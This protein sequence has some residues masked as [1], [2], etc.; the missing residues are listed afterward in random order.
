MNGRE[1]AETVYAL[2]R[3]RGLEAR[4]CYRPGE[5]DV[6]AEAEVRGRDDVSGLGDGLLSVWMYDDDC[7][8]GGRVDPLG[9]FLGSCAGGAVLEFRL[10]GDGEAEVSASLA[11]ATPVYARLPPARLAGMLAGPGV[12]DNAR[13]GLLP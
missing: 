8:G 3:G 11:G 1:T 4:V 7:H 10:C 2:L 5:D 6:W 9:A 12:L 13:R